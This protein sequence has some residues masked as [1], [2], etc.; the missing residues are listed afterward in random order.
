MIRSVLPI[1][2]VST[3]ALGVPQG[4]P[5]RSSGSPWIVDEAVL[6]ADHTPTDDSIRVVRGIAHRP[7]LQMRDGVVDFELAPSTSRFGG[8]AFRMAS[9]ADYEIIYFQPSDDRQRWA[10]VQYQP[11]YQGETTWQLYYRDGYRAIIPASIG[12]SLHVRLLVRGDRADVHIRGL[13]EPLLKIRELKRPAVSGG[14][15]FWA[16]GPQAAQAATAATSFSGLKLDSRPPEPLSPAAPEQAPDTQLRQWHVSARQPSPGGDHAATS[17][18]SRHCEPGTSVAHRERRT[19][20]PRESHAS[21]G[22]S[23]WGTART[24]SAAPVSALR[25]RISASPVIAIAPSSCSSPTATA[26]ACT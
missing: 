1:V 6:P 10:S 20:G 8:L 7:D 2:I 4:S 15:G 21:V 14:I 19:V 25:T 13:D 9:T 12:G 3:V 23:G 17:A 26:S 5:T 18:L 16:A 24:C 11:V 22:K